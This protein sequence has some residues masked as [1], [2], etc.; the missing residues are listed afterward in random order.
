MSLCKHFK[1]FICIATFFSLFATKSFA[2]GVI[3]LA[4]SNTSLTSDGLYID[5]VVSGGK[6]YGVEFFMNVTTKDGASL[7]D[8]R[9]IA[10]RSYVYKGS[11]DSYFSPDPISSNGTIHILSLGSMNATDTDEGVSGSV[12]TFLLKPGPSGTGS[13]SISFVN[14]DAMLTESAV[15]PAQPEY[16]FEITK[17]KIQSDSHTDTD[18]VVTNP[19]IEQKVENLPQTSLFEISTRNAII[20]GVILLV[21]GVFF[22]KIYGTT[23]SVVVAS[24]N[25]SVA[26]AS[27]IRE[28]RRTKRREKF[29]DKF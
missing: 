19:P 23:Q 6:S 29:E 2:V 13:M 3:S 17:Q 11:Y 5:V 7:V 22:T 9:S 26:S 10:G 24:K 27:A 8:A 25:A 1:I 16:F 21:V 20:A 4:Q 18:I 12:T 28:H 14:T 15:K